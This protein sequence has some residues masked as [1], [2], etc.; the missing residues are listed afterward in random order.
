MPAS[1]EHLLDPQ[2]FLD[3][4]ADRELVFEQQRQ[5]LAQVNGPRP[6]VRQHART[7]RRPSFA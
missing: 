4:V 3:L 2:H 7:K 5:V 1:L 6:L